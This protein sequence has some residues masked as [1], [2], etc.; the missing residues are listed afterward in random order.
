MSSDGL[1]ESMYALENEQH[2]WNAMNSFTNGSMNVSQ[3][4][5]ME[6]G[7]NIAYGGNTT[8]EYIVMNIFAR[9]AFSNSHS[10]RAKIQ[11]A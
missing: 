5:I 8:N 2:Y 9:F 11:S 6:F 3:K 7:R 4:S 1:R 10:Y